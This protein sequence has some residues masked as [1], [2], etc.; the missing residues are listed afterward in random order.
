MKALPYEFRIG[1]AVVRVS[2]SKLQA[3]RAAALAG[4]DFLRNAIARKGSARIIV[5]T[6]NSQEEMVATLGEFRDIAWN[7]IDVF[8]MDEYVG[9]DETHPASFRLWVKTRL[10]DLVHPRQAHYLNG[11]AADLAEECARYGELLRSGPIDVCFLGI[12]ENG[13]IAFNDP[14]VADFRD[15]LTV[16]RVELDARCRQQQVGEGHF[17]DLAVVP[18][19]ALTLT[20]PALMSARRLVCCAPERRK[21][22]AVMNALHG[23]ISTA[24]P[25][26]IIRTIPGAYFF[27]DAESS[28]LLPD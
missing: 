10:V 18:R 17:P 27:L 12:G 9:L 13:H 11:N 16:K 7:E 3:G 2:A 22:E 28:S 20:C 24:C 25:G 14:H 26:S 19:E 21:A 15:P 6:G 8:H 5:A 4:A 1:H 23:P